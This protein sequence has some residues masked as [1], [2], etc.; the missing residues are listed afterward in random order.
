MLTKIAFLFIHFFLIVLLNLLIIILNLKLFTL[1]TLS[2][3]HILF[4][5]FIL[6]IIVFIFL[7]HVTNFLLVLF[8]QRF[9]IRNINFHSFCLHFPN[10]LVRVY[11]GFLNWSW[12]RAMQ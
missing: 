9:L 10:Y 4:I 5:L 12:Y 8:F 1:L 7:P 6:L 3:H 11:P 2:T